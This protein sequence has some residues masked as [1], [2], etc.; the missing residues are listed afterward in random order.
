[1][2]R[3]KKQIDYE[4]A[5]RLARI[6]CTNEEI[7]SC[8]GINVTYWYTM[9]KNDPKLGDVIEKA[10]SEGKASLR[11][12]QWQ[13]AAQGNVTMQIWLGK[14]LL[15][16][17]DTQRTELTGRDGEAI[18]IEEESEAARSIIQAAL[19]RAATRREEGESHI[20]T[21]SETTH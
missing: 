2:A 16:Q 21:E 7:A 6:H 13:N 10:R 5:E 18:R 9:L 3:P 8:L 12:L 14:Q 17:N 11:R 20:E 1:M 19:D 4:A 15:D